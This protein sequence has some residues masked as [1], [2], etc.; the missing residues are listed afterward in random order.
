MI[1][2]TMSEIGPSE[3]NPT[4]YLTRHLEPEQR[5]N[6]EQ[7]QHDREFLATYPPT[8]RGI[9]Y[10]IHNGTDEAGSYL[11]AAQFQKL[12]EREFVESPNFRMKFIY[13]ILLKKKGEGV[14][15]V[16]LND[17]AFT[18]T[19]TGETRRLSE[20][21]PAGYEVF[22]NPD[23]DDGADL[24]DYKDK[25]LIFGG[26]IRKLDTLLTLYHEIGHAREYEAL[27]PDG[28]KQIEAANKIFMG[29]LV[30]VKLNERGVDEQMSEA[31]NEPETE[32]DITETDREP[33]N[34]EV[35]GSEGAEANLAEEIPEMTNEVSSALVLNLERNALSYSLKTL[36]PFLNRPGMPEL[37]A[38][39]VAA[40]IHSH[41]LKIL[42]DNIKDIAR[43]QPPV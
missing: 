11:Y 6:A 32:G 40:V 34:Q 27:S 24:M 12:N 28:K 29:G 8:Q 1:I 25:L 5:T 39:R 36:K 37:E 35:A 30:D 9:E 15:G 17:F 2:L 14:G 21:L 26:D 22:Y 19:D 41:Q 23:L 31:I 3:V 16:R 4:Q 20:H 42:S 10:L 18:D 13:D 38:Q 43:L 33:A 7:I